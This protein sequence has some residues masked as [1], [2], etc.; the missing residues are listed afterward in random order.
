MLFRSGTPVLI[1]N[2]VNI[3]REIQLDRAGLVDEDDEPGT[4]R[5]LQNWLH[6]PAEEKDAM[7][8]IAR[9]CFQSRFEVTRAADALI[10]TIQAPLKQSR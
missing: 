7:R 8:K 2:K 9:Q 6:L 4:T 5:L 3:W 10:E 1:S